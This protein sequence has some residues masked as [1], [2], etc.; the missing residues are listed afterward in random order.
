ADA[1]GLEEV[2]HHVGGHQH[3]L[4]R[5]NAIGR[6]RHLNR[7]QQRDAGKPAVAILRGCAGKAER[8]GRRQRDLAAAAKRGDRSLDAG[9]RGARARARDPSM[10]ISPRQLVLHNGVLYELCSA[11]AR[12]LNAP[13][14]WGRIVDMYYQS[15]AARAKKHSAATWGIDSTPPGE[16]RQLEV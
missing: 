15:P 6:P 13:R 16:L 7:L 3:G 9:H 5:R 12:T 2:A 10:P 14:F 8:W 4:R 1:I 11:V